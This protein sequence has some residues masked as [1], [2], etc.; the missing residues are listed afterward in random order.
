MQ[1]FLNRHVSK[2]PNTETIVYVLFYMIVAVCI[3]RI[4]VKRMHI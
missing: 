1:Q 4:I 2:I 3:L